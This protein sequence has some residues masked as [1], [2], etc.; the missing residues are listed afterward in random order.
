MV[1][2]R[3]NSGRRDPEPDPRAADRTGM[4][5]AD[6]AGSTVDLSALQA[7]DALLD[8]LGSGDSELSGPMS[9]HRVDALLLAWRREVDA[10]PIGELVD[11]ETAA[12]VVTE[13][14][15]ELTGRGRRKRRFLVPLT[16]A[17]A[18]LLIGF[19]VVG[20]AARSAMPGDTL[21]GVTQVLYSDHATS[22][23]AAANVRKDLAQAK[24]ALHSG[25]SD[26]CRVMLNQ[27]G[28]SLRDVRDE[29]GRKQLSDSREQLSDQ[30]DGAQTNKPNGNGSPARPPQGPPS[31]GQTGKPTSAS[32]PAQST[33][34]PDRP[35]TPP[36]STSTKPSETTT[37]PPTTTTPNSSGGGH[38][39]SSPDDHS[40]SGAT[41]G[42]RTAQEPA[43]PAT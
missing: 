18:V 23:E 29:D 12:R 35:T 3:D 17:A 5:G 42:G 2:R 14:N 13:A 39:P 36:D 33:S 30:L 25:N 15:E 27:V 6:E 28:D 38:N 24:V 7:D 11:T 16:S 37:P 32:N 4:T 34:N 40:P 19:T 41:E 9:R 26:R 43:A 8:A 10:E 21:W 20:I 1:K 22:V 31:N